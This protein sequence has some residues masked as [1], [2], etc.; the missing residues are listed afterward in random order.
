MTLLL[1]THVVIWWLTDDLTLSSEIKDR[2]DHEPEVYVSAATI[3]EIA[4]KQ[5]IG[6][7]K[8]PERLPEIVRDSGFRNLPI[9]PDHAIMAGQ[10]PMIHRDP[11][12]RMLVAQARSENLVLA[13]RDPAIQQYDV[14]VLVV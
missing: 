7:I 1:D 5:A 4:I 2:L 14:P 10:L 13:S 9:T 6:K 3:W 8:E 11:F 12:D